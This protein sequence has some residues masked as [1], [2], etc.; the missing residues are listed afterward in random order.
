MRNLIISRSL[1]NYNKYDYQPCSNQTA[2]RQST[3]TDCGPILFL[4]VFFIACPV[5]LR[6]RP[7]AFSGARQSFNFRHALQPLLDTDAEPGFLASGSIK[8]HAASAP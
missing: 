6:L 8:A 2:V 4:S 5:I 1:G 3:P 7:K